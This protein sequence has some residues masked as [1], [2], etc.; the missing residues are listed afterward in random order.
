MYLDLEIQLLKQIQ[1]LKKKANFIAIKSE[2]EAEGSDNAEIQYVQSLSKKLGIK[3]YVKIGGVEA[4]ND[5]YNC[6]KFGVDGIIAPMV[7]SRFGMKKFISAVGE[8]KTIK[9]PYLAIN[10]ETKNAVENIVNILN[11]S[12]GNIHGAT[13]GRS[14]LAASYFSKKITPNCSFIT[15]QIINILPI[16]KKHKLVITVGGKIDA[17]TLKIYKKNKKIY[18]SVNQIET[19]KI[20][21]SSKTLLNNFTLLKKALMFEKTYLKTINKFSLLKNQT[22][23]QRIKF[24]TKRY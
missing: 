1:D 8:Y 2:Y 20:I 10:I 23:M 24:L 13:I 4:K 19:R 14:D 22:K 7:E 6:I 18:K 15:N 5:I 12:K 21:F 16:I 9:K 17:N 11:E 3:H